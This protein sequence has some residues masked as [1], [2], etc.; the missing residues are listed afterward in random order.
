MNV[1]RLI[2]NLDKN[3]TPE[4]VMELEYDLCRLMQIQGKRETTPPYITKALYAFCRSVT[5]E[6]PEYINVSKTQGYRPNQCF[7]NVQE[8]ISR[9]GGAMQ[10]GWTIWDWPNIMITAEAHA[11][12]VS[13]EGEKYDITPKD[14]TKILFLPDSRVQ[15]DG[16]SMPSLRKPYTNS[17]L[18]M[19]LI[20]L[21]DYMDEMTSMIEPD[22]NDNR[23]VSLPAPILKRIHEIQL[24]FRQPTNQNSTCPCQSGL[25]YK[26]CC[27][28]Q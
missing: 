7:P 28:K 6:Q 17:P 4:E 15:Y 16:Y 5:V 27:G 9:F 26:R 24:I 13:P 20:L 8:Q 14:E 3:A 21:R 23:I 2:D 25:K 18:V 11:N 22:S 1:K 12:W 19:E 10:C